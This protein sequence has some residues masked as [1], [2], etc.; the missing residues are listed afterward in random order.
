[1]SRQPK[2]PSELLRTGQ[3]PMAETLRHYAQFAAQLSQ[4]Q[5]LFK[6]CVDKAPAQHCQLVNIRDG[7]L[8]IKA[9]S[10]SWST[11]LK[12]QQAA[13]IT[14]FQNNA[15]VPV[16]KLSVKVSPNVNTTN[17][18]AQRLRNMA[19]GCSEPLRLQLEAL[20]AKFDNNAANN[21]G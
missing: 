18:N 4:W 15:T 7:E 11:K 19:E 20:A 1:M 17:D 3:Q 16:N 13:I 5:Q 12:F 21:K 6:N 9:G 2:T 8:I 14:Y 10:G